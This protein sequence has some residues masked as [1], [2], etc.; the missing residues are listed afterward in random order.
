M[1]GGKGGDG[2]LDA[3]EIAA[4]NQQQ[5]GQQ[6]QLTEYS[7]YL[8]NVAAIQAEARA[9]AREEKRRQEEAERLR[10]AEVKRAGF[11]NE[12]EAREAQM[13]AEAGFTDDAEITGELGALNLDA[14]TIERPGYENLEERPD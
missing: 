11:E 10:L 1:G 7:S 6:M 5:F 2:G 13:L 8:Q 4:I 9:D 14:P 3:G 12:E